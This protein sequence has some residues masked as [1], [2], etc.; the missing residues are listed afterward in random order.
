[1]D[2]LQKIIDTGV[3]E[4]KDGD[5]YTIT[6]QFDEE[7]WEQVSEL[8]K[9][10]PAEPTSDWMKDLILGKRRIYKHPEP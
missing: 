2:E 4:V 10:F 5:Y 7:E 6:L 9:I 1:M 8:Y 3:L